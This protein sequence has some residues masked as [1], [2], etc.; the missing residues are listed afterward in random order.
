MEEEIIRKVMPHSTESEQSVLGA[1]MLDNQAITTAGEILTGDD[2][3]NTQ[4]GIIFDAMQEL[5]SSGRPVDLITLQ[6]ILK[7]KNL[8]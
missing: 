1:M 2:F 3:Y 5:A 4:Y 6:D 7:E 8:K